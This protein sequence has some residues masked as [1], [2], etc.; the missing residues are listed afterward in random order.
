Q[1]SVELHVGAATGA[2]ALEVE[3]RCSR[4]GGAVGHTL[5]LPSRSQQQ[6]PVDRQ[7]GRREKKRQAEGEPHQGLPAGASMA[8]GSA[9]SGRLIPPR[10]G[11]TH[12]TCSARTTGE[13]AQP[14]RGRSPRSTV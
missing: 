6:A 4:A 8:H 5:E 9:P 10:K 1:R 3:P 12:S 14:T 7:A 11:S 13:E 2:Q